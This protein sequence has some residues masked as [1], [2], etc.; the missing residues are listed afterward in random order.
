MNNKEVLGEYCNFILSNI[1]GGCVVVIVIGL[2][3]YK[4][5]GLFF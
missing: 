1:V 4:V 5:L 3:S 2:G